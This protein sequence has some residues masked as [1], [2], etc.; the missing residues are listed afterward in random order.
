MSEAGYA[1][2]VPTCYHDP[3][4]DHSTVVE[5][6]PPVPC[7]GWMQP[8]GWPSMFSVQSFLVFDSYEKESQGSI[9]LWTCMQNVQDLLMPLTDGHREAPLCSGDMYSNHTAIAHTPSYSCTFMHGK[10][11]AL[12]KSY[13]MEQFMEVVFHDWW[14]GKDSHY[15]TTCN[16]KHKETVQ[17]PPRKRKLFL[18]FFRLILLNYLTVQEKKWSQTKAPPQEQRTQK[19]MTCLGGNP[20]LPPSCSC[21]WQI[22]SIF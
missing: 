1:F 7:G 6:S 16:G 14:S 13:H 5:K 8:G 2:S 21:R 4:K 18:H 3:E 20:A 10:R 22:S 9:N 19:S 12:L 15:A 17:G 11:D